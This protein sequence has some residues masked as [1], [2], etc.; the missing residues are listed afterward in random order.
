MLLGQRKYY[1]RSAWVNLFFDIKVNIDDY[2]GDKPII[3]QLTWNAWDY[4][5]GEENQDAQVLY[6]NTTV[7]VVMSFPNVEGS[8]PLQ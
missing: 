8:I 1:P 2:Y 5:I 6:V 4:G 3:V 7:P